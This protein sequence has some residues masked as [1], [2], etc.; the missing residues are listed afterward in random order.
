VKCFFTRSREA[1]KKIQ[2]NVAI[3][4]LR[5]VNV[6]GH[7]KIKMDL[8][9]AL[10]ESLGLVDVRTYIQSGNVVFRTKE[11]NPERLSGVIADGI[12]RSFGF[13]PGVVVR[14]ASDLRGV[15]AGNPFAGRPGIEPNKLHVS[16][17]SGE[18][19][20]DARDKVLG[21]KF[22]PEELHIAGRELYIFFPNGMGQSKL[23]MPLVEKT[24]KTS[25]TARNWN[26]VLKLMEMAEA[27]GGP[28]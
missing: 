21:I 2:M 20:S 16:F 4:L 18:P 23:S 26:T 5:G 24:L 22:D 9:R 25:G 17:L 6:G 19:H 13:R 12:E 10:Y 8:L 7:H 11:R 27:L 15:I 3:S 28:L 14:T 1:A